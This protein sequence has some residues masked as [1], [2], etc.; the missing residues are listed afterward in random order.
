[1]LAR[2]RLWCAALAIVTAAAGTAIAKEGLEEEAAA[3]D[4]SH[5]AARQAIDARRYAEALRVLGEA[6]ARD[7]QNAETHNLLGFAYRKMGDLEQAFRHYQEALRLNPEHR[8][9]HE[10]IGE[11]Y[12]AVGNLAK[13]EEHLRRLEALCQSPCEEKVDL[14]AA[15]DTY[16]ARRRTGATPI[17]AR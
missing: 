7:T 14:K 16:K 15:I 5:V 12:L 11:A 13:A 9:A 6:L 1:M 2:A 3:R 8:G 4:P 10:Y 17:P